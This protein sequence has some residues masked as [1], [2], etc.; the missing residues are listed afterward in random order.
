[1]YSMNGLHGKFIVKVTQKR[2]TRSDWITKKNRKG[3][4]EKEKLYEVKTLNDFKWSHENIN[5]VVI[6]K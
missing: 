5:L 3:K 6:M 1:M 2:M 4:T